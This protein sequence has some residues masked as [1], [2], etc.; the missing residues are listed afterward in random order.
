MLSHGGRI[1]FKN[2]LNKVGE[3]YIFFYH[4]TCFKS[5][6]AAIPTLHTIDTFT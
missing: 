2:F 1:E 4:V 6:N 3:I 5:C